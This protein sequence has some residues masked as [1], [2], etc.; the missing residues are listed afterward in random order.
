MSPKLNA[1]PVRESQLS[2]ESVSFNISAFL[3]QTS[4]LHGEELGM[5]SPPFLACLG[6]GCEGHAANFMHVYPELQTPK[7][8]QQGLQETSCFRRSSLIDNRDN[9][10]YS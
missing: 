9:L 4:A 1:S 8:S 7:P 3:S 2:Q 10:C 5:Q 6:S